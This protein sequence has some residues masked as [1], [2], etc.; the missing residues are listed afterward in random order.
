MINLEE[1]DFFDR[2]S[3]IEHLAYAI[4]PFSDQMYIGDDYK[5]NPI[6]LSDSLQFIVQPKGQGYHPKT[7]S[8]EVFITKKQYEI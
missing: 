5:D 8:K 2:D 1:R 4:T 6:A 7:V 3:L